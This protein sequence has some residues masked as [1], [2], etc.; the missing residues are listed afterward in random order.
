MVDAASAAYF[1]LHAT[2]DAWLEECCVISA[3][4]E[5]R[6]KKLYENFSAW[7]KERGEGVPSQTRWGEFMAP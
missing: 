5:E 1:E 7:K 3:G 4:H 2:F 6:A